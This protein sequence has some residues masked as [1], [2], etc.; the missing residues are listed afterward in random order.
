M[1]VKYGTLRQQKSL[2]HEV[3]AMKETRSDPNAFKAVVDKV[4][5]ERR[6]KELD[7]QR[8]TITPPAVESDTQR[9]QLEARQAQLAEF[10]I[11][12]CDRIHKPA[13]PSEHEQWGVPVGTVGKN[14]AWDHTVKK[15]TVDREGNVVPA[16]GGYGAISEWKD[17]Q[18]RLYREE[19]EWDT[20]IAS[21]ERLRTHAR[22]STMAEFKRANYAPGSGVS[23]E[24]WNA[25]V[26]PRPSK[27]QQKDVSV[28]IR[29]PWQGPTCQFV[30]ASGEK[31]G[32]PSHDGS[33][34]CF[35]KHHRPKDETKP[36]PDN[37]PAA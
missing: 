24:Q 8:T 21:V 18:H 5:F 6:L 23:E 19:E 26:G 36:E 29:K 27:K 2:E 9:R 4:Q 28:K 17:N 1:A 16:Q 10:I 30:K 3:N 11:N 32:A 7:H 13:M 33:G 14:R 22:P 12:P 31:C 15:F 35:S 37:K 25:T 20:E 34:Y